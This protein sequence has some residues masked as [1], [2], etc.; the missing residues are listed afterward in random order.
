[1]DDDHIFHKTGSMRH[2]CAVLQVAYVLGGAT[3]RTNAKDG[4]TVFFF[5][6]SS[7]RTELSLHIVTPSLNTYINII[8]LVHS[9]S[10]IIL[11][12]VPSQSW[13]F[14]FICLI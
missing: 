10:N 6:N 1:M 11:A 13:S 2:P 8:L 9:K 12:A 4:P 7:I 3:T 14:L 5:L